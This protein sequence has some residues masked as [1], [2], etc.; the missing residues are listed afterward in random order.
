[1]AK[2]MGHKIAK[3][4]DWE[5]GKD[6]KRARHELQEARLWLATQEKDPAPLVP[7]MPLKKPV[8]HQPDPESP[9]G[10]QAAGVGQEG[11]L[12]K[13]PGMMQEVRGGM[14]GAPTG[15]E[16]R[17]VIPPVK[18]GNRRVPKVMQDDQTTHPLIGG[19][20]EGLGAVRKGGEIQIK[21]CGL[22]MCMGRRKLTGRTGPTSVSVT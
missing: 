15:E 17:G 6:I 7:K 11:D 10:E 5:P 16:E 12:W 1:M 8:G 20:W 3:D 18:A 14:P 4:E 22:V 2:A 21:V 13:S 9:R 19:V